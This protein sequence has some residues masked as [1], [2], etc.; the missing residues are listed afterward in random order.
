VGFLAGYLSGHF[1]IGGGLITTPAIRLWLDRPALI[2]VGT[3]LAINIPT[4]IIG[5]IAYGRKGLIARHLVGPLAATGVIGV[6]AGAAVTPIVGGSPIL[7]VTAV[8]IFILSWRFTLG[9][10]ATITR[11]RRLGLPALAL[12]GLAIGFFSGLLGLGG[13]FLLVP[14][15]SLLLGLDM[16]TT[17]GTSL[18]VVAAITIPGALAHYYLGN[19]DVALSLR[20]MVGVVPGVLIGSSVAMALPNRWLKVMFGIFLAVIGILLGYNEV[21]V[22]AS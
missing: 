11:P 20:M 18:A 12:S 19:V 6:V 4:A 9:K 7:L 21:V 3:P 17:F 16:K 14:F 8:L 1:G 13:G 10:E 15:L 22:L 5:A 2:A